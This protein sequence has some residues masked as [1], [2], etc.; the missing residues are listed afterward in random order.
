MAIRLLIL[1]AATTLFAAVLQEVVRLYVMGCVG[2]AISI[3]I[4]TILCMTLVLLLVA[5]NKKREG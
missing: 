2:S 5:Y 4:T 3:G 1:I